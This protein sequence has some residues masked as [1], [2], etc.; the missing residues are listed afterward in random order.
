MLEKEVIVVSNML[1]KEISPALGEIQSLICSSC[2]KTT[3]G[4]LRDTALKPTNLLFKATTDGIPFGIISAVEGYVARIDAW[5]SNKESKESW[6]RA[7]NSAVKQIFSN[8]S[9]GKIEWRITE[10]NKDM[11]EVAKSCGFIRQGELVG[12]G[13]NGEPLVLMGL[14]K[15]KIQSPP[16]AVLE[17]I[18]VSPAE[19][20]EKDKLIKGLKSRISEPEASHEASQKE[21]DAKNEL[22][23]NLRQDPEI[24]I[25]AEVKTGPKENKKLPQKELTDSPKKLKLGT[26]EKTVLKLLI[27]HPDDGIKQQE[28][29]RETGIQQTRVSLA[30]RK[31]TEKGVTTNELLGREK[32]VKPVMEKIQELPEELQK[33]LGIQEQEPIEEIAIPLKQSINIEEICKT[34][35]FG[36]TQRE[37]LFALKEAGG[38]LNS[39]GLRN[40]IGINKKPFMSYL[41]DMQSRKIIRVEQNLITLV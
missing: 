23:Q 9:A 39:G 37:I 5:M 24:E 16:E 36:Q 20:A 7:I 12:E 2:F 41:M 28:I 30:A 35:G 14:L 11:L 10:S 34:N 31:L 22:I 40:K 32:I 25:A 38:S 19:I 33:E 29:I 17:T 18:P 15:Q 27:E 26:D 21:L 6:T 1:L 13:L 3:E 4:K 8:P